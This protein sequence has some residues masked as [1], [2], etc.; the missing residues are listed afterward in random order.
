MLPELPGDNN[1][2]FRTSGCISKVPLSLALFCRIFAMFH[3]YSQL[4]PIFTRLPATPKTV[5]LLT[6]T[7]IDWVLYLIASGRESEWFKIFDHIWFIQN[8]IAHKIRLLNA[9]IWQW[10][11]SIYAKQFRHNCFVPHGS[12]AHIRNF[13]K[14]ECRY[15]SSLRQILCLAFLETFC[16]VPLVIQF[17]SALFPSHCFSYEFASF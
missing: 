13:N 10:G 4:R 8:K 12:F 11:C 16:V 17:E 9:A 7:V 5:R 15:F 14:F 6:A 2:F 1:Y 3:L